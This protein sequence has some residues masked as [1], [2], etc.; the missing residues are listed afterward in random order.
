[1][2]QEL[3]RSLTDTFEGHAQQ[4]E[5]GVEYWLARDIQHLLGYAEWRNFNNSAISKAK[6]AFD[7]SGHLVTDHFVG[8]NK[9]VRC[10]T[11]PTAPLLPSLQILVKPRKQRR[12]C[13]LGLL[14]VEAVSAAANR[15]ELRIAA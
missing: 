13:D 7:V 11:N 5:S 9:M 14:R 15:S 10:C 6:T 12:I 3:I 8:V 1:M 4:T 2:K